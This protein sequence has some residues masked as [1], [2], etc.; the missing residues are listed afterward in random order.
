MEPGFGNGTQN[1]GSHSVSQDRPVRRM[2]NKAGSCKARK[3]TPAMITI[4]LDD[5]AARLQVF[6]AHDRLHRA[7]CTGERCRR[8]DLSR[9]D[10]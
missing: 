10:P 1:P 8:L 4:D 3:L 7:L 9:A 2:L 5:C 6:L